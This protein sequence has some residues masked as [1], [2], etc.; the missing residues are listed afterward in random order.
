MYYKND[1]FMSI[2]QSKREV[3]CTG[4]QLQISFPVSEQVY[5][6]KSHLTTGQ[7]QPSLCTSLLT[8][9]LGRVSPSISQSDD[10]N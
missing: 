7:S 2:A 10:N 5:C 9:R 6:H 1:L 3:T 8:K 4:G